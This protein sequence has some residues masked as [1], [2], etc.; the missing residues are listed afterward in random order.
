MDGGTRGFPA[1]E[2][3][4]STPDPLSRPTPF[5]A[6]RTRGR[7]V[8][9][10]L[11][12]L[13]CLWWGWRR[14]TT[15]RIPDLPLQEADPEVVALVRACEEALRQDP[16]SPEKWGRL[17]MSLLA[18]RFEAESVAPFTQAE[19]L[20]PADPRWPYLRGIA[21][22]GRNPTA[23][24]PCLRKAASLC[25]RDER[26]GAARLRLAETL[27]AE[28]RL[29]EAAAE[30]RQ[31]PAGP[32]SP[33][34][35]YGLGALA[36][37]QGDRET[38]QRFLTRCATS[39][40]TRMKATSRLAALARREGKNVVTPKPPGDEDAP[41]PDPFLAECLKLTTGKANRMREIA[42]LER[43]GRAGQA[44]DKLRAVARDYPNAPTLLALGITLGRR[45]HFEESEAV[46][47]RCLE[48]EPHLVRAQYYLSLA[49][50]GQGEALRG[51]GLQTESIAR[52]EEAA[53]WARSATATDPGHGEA[54][55]QLG[56]AL[57]CLGRRAEAITAFRQALATRPEL[58]DS[59][60]WLGKTLAEEGHREEGLEHLRNA[61]RYAPADDPRPQKAFQ[62]VL[63]RN[64]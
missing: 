22:V 29:E 23:A 62:H 46:L 51:K 31:V 43:Q 56:M 12:A 14:A 10:V 7:I 58:P 34:V 37:A 26:G 49:L 52:F 13:P 19:A 55:L 64:K 54:H 36:A 9:V 32:L 50:F 5:P 48:L 53:A 61:L 59:H 4:M 11:L 8:L 38:A 35:D 39:P 44:L 21:L 41:W 24:V 42:D 1:S 27:A 40:F 60:L 47:R 45:G 57:V 16:R 17:G 63:E 3:T 30:F 28:G 15:P 25:D 18:N 6:G 33:C 20:A 2:S